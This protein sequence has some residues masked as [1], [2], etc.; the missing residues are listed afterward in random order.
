MS[1]ETKDP[2]LELA[3]K[4]IEL[5][6]RGGMSEEEFAVQQ[7]VD[8]ALDT[9]V[10]ENEYKEL[11]TW[12]A[13]RVA[14]DLIEHNAEFGDYS[15]ARLRPFVW[16]W[17]QRNGGERI[18]IKWSTG[19]HTGEVVYIPKAALQFAESNFIISLTQQ[20]NR[21]VRAQNDAA[22]Q[23]LTLGRQLSV[24]KKALRWLRVVYEASEK[25]HK[26]LEV[27]PE[28]RA[29]ADEQ[30]AAIKEALAGFQQYEREYAEVKEP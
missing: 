5:Q 29:Y 30:A 23:T 13:I 17:Q 10:K 14:D 25:L 26:K 27:S 20:Y 6:R 8:Q 24:A 22:M 9:A 16:D 7:K 19:P 21:I 4:V 11:V 28:L 15:P 12:D 1:E 18:E 2:E 3:D